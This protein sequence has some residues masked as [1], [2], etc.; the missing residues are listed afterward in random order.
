MYVWIW[1]RLPGP[2]AV[3]WLQALGLSSR[4]WRCCS[5]W[6][7]RGS[8]RI[9]RST[10]CRPTE[11]RH[12]VE[13]GCARLVRVSTVLVVDNYDSFVFN[14]VQYLEQL[15]ADCIVRRNDAVTTDEIAEL[16]EV[17]Q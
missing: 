2:T 3:K 14:L 7:S 6:C 4:W 15:G 17:L 9:Y 5:S 12:R 1:R 16:L 11:R 10:G 13:C 8:S